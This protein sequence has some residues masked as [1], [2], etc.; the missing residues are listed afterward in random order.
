MSCNFYLFHA[1]SLNHIPVTCWAYCTA[2]RGTALALRTSEMTNNGSRNGQSWTRL[3]AYLASLQP[4][5]PYLLSVS[6]LD[7]EGRVKCRQQ[8][9]PADLRFNDGNA[10]ISTALIC[11]SGGLP[12]SLL[13]C[14]RTRHGS[15][16]Q[17]L[18]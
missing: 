12:S 18:F 14:L 11:K 2:V 8:P 3:E 9:P 16:R 5:V 7:R 13:V 1:L 15:V 10:A 4:E 17:F 6:A